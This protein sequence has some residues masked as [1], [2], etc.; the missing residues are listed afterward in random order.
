MAMADDIHDM[1]AQV[2]A[3]ATAVYGISRDNGPS[4]RELYGMWLIL[5]EIAK[6]LDVMSG[7]DTEAP[8]STGE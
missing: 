8:E 2:D 6:K 3:I 1:A 7:Y 4:E 5:V